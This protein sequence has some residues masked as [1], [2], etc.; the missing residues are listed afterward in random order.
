M[1]R[2]PY[3]APAQIEQNWIRLGV[4]VSGRHF[5]NS[6]FPDH[7]LCLWAPK[8]YGFDPALMKRWDEA[9]LSAMDQNGIPFGHPLRC[10][11]SCSRALNGRPAEAKLLLSYM[12]RRIEGFSPDPKK[13]AAALAII[14]VD[15]FRSIAGENA[16]VY[17]ER[18]GA[19][20][21]P[22]QLAARDEKKL[23]AAGLGQTEGSPAA[24]EPQGLRI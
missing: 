23:L 7:T 12:P 6:P 19:F 22:P 15:A 16:P 13:D 1:S 5:K 9:C 21:T 8:P 3:P 14:L 24:R 10:G 4:E 11:T 17:A 20:I 2:V 18:D